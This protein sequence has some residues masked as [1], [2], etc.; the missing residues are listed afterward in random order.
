MINL[1]NFSDRD[2]VVPF[3]SVGPS[4]LLPMP[5]TLHNESRGFV[6]LNMIYTQIN[7]MDYV[8]DCFQDPSASHPAPGRPIFFYFL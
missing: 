2:L 1:S 5:T 4:R 8:I 3:I 6:A 7:M